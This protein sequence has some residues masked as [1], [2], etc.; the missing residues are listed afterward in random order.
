MTARGCWPPPKKRRSI[1]ASP[2]DGSCN[3]GDGL[4][5]DL[6]AFLE[7]ASTEPLPADLVDEPDELVIAA[8]PHG[9]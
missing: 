1:G 9:W 5:F 8:E 7:S 3:A 6:M 2:G 4:P